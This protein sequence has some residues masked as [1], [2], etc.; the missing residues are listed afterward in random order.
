MRESSYP[1]VYSDGHHYYTLSQDPI[2]VYG[3]KII[4]EKGKIYRRWDPSRSKLSAAMHLGLESFEFKD[5]RILY[6]GA[7]TG[8][9][10]SHISDIADIVWAV[11]ISPIS[12]HSLINLAERRK[13]IIPILNDARKPE[14][15]EIFVDN[16]DTVYQDISQRD[17]VDIFLKNMEYYKPKIGYLMLK[18]PTID[19]R[20]RPKEI[21][22]ST[23]KKIEEFMNVIEIINLKRY[24]RDHYAIVVRI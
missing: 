6:L 12:M 1:G 3:E 24:Q 8:T 10:V 21:L 7:A 9:T 19:I 2:P 11:E 22:K 15:Y 23:V 16:P 5:S 4:E 18:T 13:N 20:K 17:Q 14:E